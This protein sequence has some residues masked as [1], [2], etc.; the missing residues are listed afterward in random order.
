[1]QSPQ[2]TPDGKAMAFILT[3]NHAGNIWEQRLTGGDPMQLTKFTNGDM[4]SFSWS[5]DGKQLAFSRGV[6][7]TDVVMM[8]NFR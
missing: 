5:K 6:R 2:F 3:R 7:K 8:S 4:F 1:M